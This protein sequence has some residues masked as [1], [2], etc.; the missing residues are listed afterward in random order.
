MTPTS[1]PLARLIDDQARATMKNEFTHPEAEPLT[2]ERSSRTGVKIFVASG[3]ALAA[4]AAVIAALH[5]LAPSVD[6]AVAAAPPSVGV[7]VPIQREVDGR[8]EFLG[9]FSAV[10]QVDLRAQVGGTLTQIGFKDGDIVHQGDLLFL[11]DPTPYQIKFSEATAQLE[12]ARARLG[13]A[14]RETE[15][16]AG[17]FKLS[18]GLAEFDL[19]RGRIDQ[20]QQITLVYDIAV[21]EADLG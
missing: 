21:L 20:E 16:R 10:Q 5:F 12:S 2:I 6:Q 1:P 17:A 15:T 13:L 11:I 19:I 4:T 3:V 14:N 8:L 18:R 7:S 9:Q